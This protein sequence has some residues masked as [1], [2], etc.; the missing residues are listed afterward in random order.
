MKILRYYIEA[1][2]AII[3]YLLFRALPLSSAS[4]FGGK[5][6]QY[7]GPKT[8][9]HQ[10]AWRNLSDAMPELT[11]EEKNAV[12][13]RMWDNLGRVFCEYPHL[14]HPAMRR[15][16]RNISGLE[17][18]ETARSS[19]R[20]VLL[21]SGHLGNWE[22]LPVVADMQGMTLHLLYRP[23]NNPVVDRLVA[24]IRRPYSRGL[25]AKGM[26]SARGITRAMRRSEPVAMLV[27][28]KTNDG[29]A[30]PLFGR[31]AMT[32][33]A[34]AHFVQRYNALILPVC[35]RRTTGA[36]FD[37][38]IE[39]PM[40]FAHPDDRL[41]VMTEVNTLIERWIRDDPAQWFWVH[42]R[43]PKNGSR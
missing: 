25:Y 39:P 6:A 12:T 2:F 34:V 32:T 35:C 11:T 21:I 7:I 42:R 30:V 19:G 41:A 9:V 5:V 29:I 8:K 31:D 27:D 13:A 28:Q 24:F 23:A 4:A 16:I 36:Q 14:A 33:D 17:Y 15:C 20:P 40:S 1:F 22:L 43:W 26:A 18:V 3:A 10:V 37:I 38:T